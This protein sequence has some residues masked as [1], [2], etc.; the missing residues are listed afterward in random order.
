MPGSG[1]AGVAFAQAFRSCGPSGMPNIFISYRREDTSGDAG[2]LAA[3]LAF[4]F[5]RAD[6]FIDVDGISGGVNF[7]TRIQQALDRSR[8]TF[9]LIGDRWLTAAAG[10]GSRRLD[11]E[12]DYVRREIAAALSREDVTVVP[13]LV[14]GARM[15]DSSELP[16]DIAALATRNALPLSAKRWRYDVRQIYRV[17]RQYD[18]WWLRQWRDVP[19]RYRIAMPTATVAVVGTALALLL[20]GG[21]GT[22]SIG[23]CAGVS[24]DVV[25]TTCPFAQNVEKTYAAGPGGDS[26]IQAFSPELGKYILMHCVVVEGPRVNCS[27]GKDASVS[28]RPHSHT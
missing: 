6:V 26:A 15:P 3:D 18:H 1:A 17:A 10:D 24:R 28:F 13:V 5:G 4:R 27:G 8:V 16:K 19:L 12:R 7:E 21:R 20:A 14:E 11:D 2:H 23:G 25:T 9:V 22:A